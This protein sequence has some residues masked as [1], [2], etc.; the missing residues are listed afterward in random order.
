MNLPR[1][2]SSHHCIN[3]AQEMNKNERD[4]NNINARKERPFLC[5]V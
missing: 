2:N 1:E 5:C 3:D 4:Y